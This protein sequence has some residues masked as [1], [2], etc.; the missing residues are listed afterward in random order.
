MSIVVCYCRTVPDDRMLDDISEDSMKRRARMEIVADI[1]EVAK[2]E[3]PKLKIMYQASLSFSQL[4]T[5][6]NF[7]LKSGLI[8][9]LKMN[10]KVLYKT[11]S[12]G[13]QYLK[14]YKELKHL[15]HQRNEALVNIHT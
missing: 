15:L 9:K 6:L 10:G 12:K 7:L 2:E 1:L 13:N 5:Y 4:T 3:T 14:S 11:T 8:Q